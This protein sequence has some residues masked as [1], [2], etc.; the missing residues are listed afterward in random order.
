MPPKPR[1][2]LPEDWILLGSLGS[3]PCPAHQTESGIVRAQGRGDKG[4]QPG[5]FPDKETS[6]VF[7]PAENGNNAPG[8]LPKPPGGLG[9]G[10]ELCQGTGL[11]V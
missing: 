6:I 5:F 2:P 1:G 11:C 3:L 4:I 10:A 7:V 8:L 9:P